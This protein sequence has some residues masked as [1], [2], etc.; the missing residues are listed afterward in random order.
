MLAHRIPAF[1]P[2]TTV[3]ADSV[4]IIVCEFMVDVHDVR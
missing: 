1:V 3:F 2:D 4:E